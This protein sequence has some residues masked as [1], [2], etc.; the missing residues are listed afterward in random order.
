MEP[1]TRLNNDVATDCYRD[2]SAK[3]LSPDAAS[4]QE[5]QRV[6]GARHSIQELK[7]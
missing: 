3:L 5:K 1:N 2:K 4:S 7:N 6:Y